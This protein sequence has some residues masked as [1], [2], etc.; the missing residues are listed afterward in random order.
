M[1]KHPFSESFLRSSLHKALMPLR[2][3]HFATRASS[4]TKATAAAATTTRAQAPS[5]IPTN[6]NHPI[7]TASHSL[8][9]RLWTNSFT[10]FSSAFTSSPS[11]TSTTTIATALLLY[12]SLSLS[13][14]ASSSTSLVY[15]AP[16]GKPATEDV[17]HAM[18]LTFTETSALPLQLQIEA[19][20]KGKQQLAYLPTADSWA[21]I[22][23]TPQSKTS[24]PMRRSAPSLDFYYLNYRPTYVAGTSTLDFW[25]LTPEG[26]TAP[27]T[28]SLELYD[29]FNR[30][31]LAVLVPAGTKVPANTANKHEPFLWKSWKVPK[32]LA[33]E[34]DFS[35]RFRLVL[36]TS[37]DTKVISANVHAKR[38][39]DQ[40]DGDGVMAEEG[41]QQPQLET[42]GT[43]LS[44]GSSRLPRQHEVWAVAMTMVM[45]LALGLSSGAP[46]L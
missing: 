6:N 24:V 11:S 37:D 34:F 27:K 23:S 15:A 29:E 14:L 41:Q 10:P 43:Q 13:L 7:K 1:N 22:E 12:L 45:A 33:S 46:L 36:K 9:G 19:Q 25:M 21:T 8:R 39:L 28:A 17:V 26:T 44:G 18:R 3:V 32:S 38:D 35:D 5:S 40:A 20:V 30:V 42:D 2:T 16:K 4:S 31:L